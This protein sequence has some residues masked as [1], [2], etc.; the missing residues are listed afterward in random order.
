VSRNPYLAAWRTRRRNQQ[1]AEG[2]ATTVARWA[3][4]AVA[5]VLLVPLFRPVFL[6]FLDDPERHALGVEGVLQRVGIAM[7]AI[8]TLDVYTALIR[9]PDR[10][11]LDL[12]PVDA[13]QVATFEIVRVA[14]ERAWLLPAAALL[15]SPIGAEAS[16]GLYGLGL[17]CVAGA[18]TL[19]LCASA[20]V[21]LL[22][23]DVAESPEWAPILD[24][25]RG[26]N[27]RPQAAFLY[28]PG[29]VLAG[30]GGLVLV[31]AWGVRAAW[32]G[33]PLA[34]ILLLLPFAGAAAALVPVAGIARRS[35]FRASAVLADIDARYAA[36]ERPEEAHRVYLDWAVRWLP[37]GVATWALKDLRHGWRAR[38]GWI[39]GAW[40]AG[41]GAA[42]VGWA[43]D[44]AAAARAAAVVAAAAWGTATIGVLMERDEPAFLRAWLPPG[45]LPRR[46]ARLVVIAGWVQGAIWPAALA[47]GLRHGTSG[48]GL[49]V[50]SGLLSAIVAAAAATA[51]GQLRDRAVWVYGPLA[52][53]AAAATAALVLR[54]A[55]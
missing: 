26:H 49:V 12:W 16:W 23:V 36:V 44:P 20:M 19:G 51:L 47:V 48:F 27:P 17:A 22:A 21:H 32:T 8:L 31:S 9:G 45:G 10:A 54:V 37:K 14:W 50:L 5:A 52:A 1:R 11:V 43:G 2:F 13:A 28:A 55:V 41:V 3:G 18:W 38:R 6:A 42:M 35:W 34:A 7:I 33:Q 46:L 53:V 25:I 40:L 24:V 4:P 29:V 39:T 15:L 30:S